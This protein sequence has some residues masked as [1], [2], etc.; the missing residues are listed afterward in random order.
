[1]CKE[2]LTRVCN[3]VALILDTA[4]SLADE[5]VADESPEEPESTKLVGCTAAVEPEPAR[6]AS[7][8]RRSRL[9]DAVGFTQK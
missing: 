4:E 2:L 7:G 9:L 8:T 6:P 3:A 1:M 5:S